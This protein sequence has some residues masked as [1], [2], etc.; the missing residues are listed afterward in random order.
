[1]PRQYDRSGGYYTHQPNNGVN[2][3]LIL[4]MMVVAVVGPL[5]ALIVTEVMDAKWDRE[6]NEVMEQRYAARKAR[7]G[8][9]AL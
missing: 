8:G 5:V 2:K 3:M 6:Y 4:I 1:M 9:A 7:K